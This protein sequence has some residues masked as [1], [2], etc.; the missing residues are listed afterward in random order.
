[1]QR[2]RLGE[3]QFA[4]ELGKQELEPADDAEEHA[5]GKRQHAEPHEP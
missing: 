2:P 5:D 4:Q 1:M 3:Q